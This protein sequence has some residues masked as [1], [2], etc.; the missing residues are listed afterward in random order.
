MSCQCRICES[1]A[2]LGVKAAVGR[3][4][5]MPRET[6]RNHLASVGTGGSENQ[7]RRTIVPSGVVAGRTEPVVLVI[8]DTHLPCVHAEA[9]V[10][11]ASYG[12]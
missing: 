1:F 12:A 7:E 2:R 11:P 10:G 9:R 5:G 6:V 3:E 8:A 4:L